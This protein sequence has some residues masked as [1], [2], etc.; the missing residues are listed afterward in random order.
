MKPSSTVCLAVILSSLFASLA[1]GR[2]IITDAPMPRTPGGLLSDSLGLLLTIEG[3]KELNPTWTN[4]QT[5][6][7][8]KLN[9]KPL[10]KPVSIWIENLE[11]KKH[12]SYV[13]KGYEN[14]TMIGTPPAIEVFAT[15]QGR[16]LETVSQTAW[17][18]RTHFVV[19]SVVESKG[20]GLRKE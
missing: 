7:V 20:I 15:Q 3:V 19:L 2:A 12:Q 13:L 14:G 16:K 11:L 5:L 18:W 17:Q 8:Q 6:V 1:T 10:A 4:D 9:G